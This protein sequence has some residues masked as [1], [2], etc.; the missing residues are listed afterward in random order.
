MFVE[1]VTHFLFSFWGVLLF[2]MTTNIC[3]LLLLFIQT[4]KSSDFFLQMF[5]NHC[6]VINHMSLGM[7]MSYALTEQ[8]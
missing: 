2:C 3:L 7:C 5:L 8:N 4:D 6:L 1:V